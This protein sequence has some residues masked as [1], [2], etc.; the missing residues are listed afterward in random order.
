[1]ERHHRMPTW[2]ISTHGEDNS[3]LFK[4]TDVEK[5]EKLV[6]SNRGNVKFHEEE[7]DMM[8]GF[9]INTT[10]HVVSSLSVKEMDSHASVKIYQ[11]L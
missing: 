2:K 3:G 5:L 8:K 4:E 7:K 1:M 11:I 10:H 9:D 6:T